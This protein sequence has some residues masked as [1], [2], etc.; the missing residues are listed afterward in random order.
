MC[1]LHAGRDTLVAWARAD[2]LQG[3][4]GWPTH[5]HAHQATNHL[6]RDPLIKVATMTGAVTQALQRHLTRHAEIPMKAAADLGLEGVRRVVA[7]M[8]HIKCLLL[9]YTKQLPNPT[10]GEHMIPLIYYHGA[11]DQDEH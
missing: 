6:F 1:P 5:S 11:H 2:T 8:A 7:E 3:H 10:A 4:E 9:A